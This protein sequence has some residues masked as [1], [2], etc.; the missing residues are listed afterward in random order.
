MLK[1]IALSE[2]S[3]FNTRLFLQSLKENVIGDYST[4]I[5][6]K[7]STSDYSLMYELIF[8]EYK[9]EKL[10]FVKVDSYKDAFLK[11]IN[12]RTDQDYVCLCTTEDV[13]YRA[14]V[15]PDLDKTFSDEEV[16][17]IHTRLGENIK[18]NSSLGAENIFKP[19]GK[20]GKL[21]KYDWTVHY[22]DFN[23]PFSIAG[24]IYRK[25]EIAKII[26]A[27]PFTT[28]EDLQEGFQMFGNYH[29]HKSLCPKKS[30]L[31]TQK[32]DQNEKTSFLTKMLTN[33]QLMK[34]ER[35]KLH[36]FDISK[37]E[38]IHKDIGIL[39]LLTGKKDAAVE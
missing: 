39:R 27:I 8:R 10:D 6:Y 12:E 37:T 16:L 36:F 20:S 14:F 22:V 32:P 21:L 3:A 29:R 25:K 19:E 7:A 1:F 23:E 34:G 18:K 35:H 13:F 17:S 24:S 2:D 30:V 33:I 4:T 38:E 31:F 5:I 11:D 28:R 26:K 15:I 9:S